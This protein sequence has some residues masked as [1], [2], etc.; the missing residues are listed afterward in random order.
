MPIVFEVGKEYELD[1]IRFGIVR[2]FVL[3]CDSEFVRLKLSSVQHGARRDY[4]P[5]E[6]CGF[7][8]SFIRTVRRVQAGGRRRRAQRK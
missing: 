7:R 5:G 1:T 4:L 3:G 2:G 8:L 6:E